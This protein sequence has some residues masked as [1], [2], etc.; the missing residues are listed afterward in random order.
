[1]SENA[2]K[3]VGFTT[4]SNKISGREQFFGGGTL[5]VWVPSQYCPTRTFEGTVCMHRL[6]TQAPPIK[7]QNNFLKVVSFVQSA[8]RTISVIEM[9]GL[10]GAEVAALCVE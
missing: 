4:E 10:I 6:P 8:R 1:M 7:R 3:V 2:T 9:P 5:I